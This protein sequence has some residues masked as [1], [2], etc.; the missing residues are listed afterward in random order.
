MN[1]KHGKYRC[2][3]CRKSFDFCAPTYM[4]LARIADLS[5]S[6]FVNFY[7]AQAEAI[8]GGKTAE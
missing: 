2:E 8:M 4:L 6:V 7:K 1:D 5:D 3:H